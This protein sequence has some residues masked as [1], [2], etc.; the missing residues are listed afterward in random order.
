MDAC[1]IYDE[2]ESSKNQ[3]E[4]LVSELRKKKS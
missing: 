2:K 3:C 4:T 1:I